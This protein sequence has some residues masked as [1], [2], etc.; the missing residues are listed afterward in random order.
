MFHKYEIQ[1]LVV[2]Y[3]RITTA[4]LGRNKN[5]PKEGEIFFTHIYFGATS[6]YLNKTDTTFAM[7]WLGDQTIY[8]YL[9]SI[10]LILL[11][12]YVWADYKMYFGLPRTY[13]IFWPKQCVIRYDIL[14]SVYGITYI[15]PQENLTECKYVYKLNGYK[16]TF[17]F[18]L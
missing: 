3:M 7:G 6:I 17:S 13:F 12:Q 4:T 16:W 18:V 5:P 2:Q 15:W 1:E 9:K 8:L 10:H 11:V 14:A